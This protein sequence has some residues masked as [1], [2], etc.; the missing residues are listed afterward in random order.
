M[1]ACGDTGCGDRGCD[2]DAGAEGQ[3]FRAGRLGA[4]AAAAQ[5]QDALVSAED[6][7]GGDTEEGADWKLEFRKS[8][9]QNVGGLVG[10]DGP[11]NAS[12]RC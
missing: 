11:A 9:G 3:R 1:G 2:D 8:K 6:V 4:A 5:A 7:G 10:G 12:P